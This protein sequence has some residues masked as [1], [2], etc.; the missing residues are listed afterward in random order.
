M[1]I[2]TLMA[3]GAMQSPSF[4][5]EHRAW[6]Q[7]IINTITPLSNYTQF[8]VEPYLFD[9]RTLEAG[10]PATMWQLK[11]QNAHDNAA[12]FLPPFF[13]SS[14]VGMNAGQILLD[15]DLEQPSELIWS[16][17]VNLQLHYAAMLSIGS[18]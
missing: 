12:E 13:G 16:L 5:L 17:F 8:A 11:H 14:A 18:S 4:G 9:P 7:V 2:D 10:A 15:S 6:H 3:G 1:A